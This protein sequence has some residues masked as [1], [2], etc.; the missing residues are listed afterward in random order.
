VDAWAVDRMLTS[1]EVGTADR[2]RV[3][4]LTRKASELYRGPFL[5]GEA[6]QFPQATALADRLR[7]RLLRRIV[8]EGRECERSAQLEEAVDWYEEALRIDPCAEDVYRSLMSAYRSLGRPTDVQETYRRCRD[9][10]A[11]LLAIDPAP[12][13]EALLE[14]TDGV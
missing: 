6:A 12:E 5:G 4:E 9:N 1:A 10:L 2:P 11:A 8:A 14:S 7:R 13:T 3:R